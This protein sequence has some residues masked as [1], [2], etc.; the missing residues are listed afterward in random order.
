[1][2]MGMAHNILAAKVPLRGYDIDAAA[3]A[4]FAAMGGTLCADAA[5]AAAQA[6]V[7]LVM[8][9]D[10]A[11]AQQVLFGTGGV[12][13][14][15]PQGATVMLCATM[16][17]A[18]VRMLAAQAAQAGLA[19]LDAPVSGGKAG[20]DQGT[21]SVMASGPAHSFAAAKPLLDAIAA[22]V[23]RLGD[24]PGLGATYKVVHQLAAGVH[25]A[26]AAELMLL[27]TRA[28]CDPAAL[29][30]I[31]SASAGQSWMLADRVPHMLAGDYTPRSMVDIFVKDMGLVLQT[32]RECATPLPL[33][34]LAYQ[35]FVSASALGYGKADDAAVLKAYEALCGA[36]TTQASPDASPSP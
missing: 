18:D 5:T 24:E 34:A 36:T 13:A 15:M 10:V 25:L 2:G 28:G 12:A 19:V 11:Q 30:E 14:A 31:V 1:M 29:F 16:A 17:P 32:G 9:V 20:A 27:G 7:V 22:R 33:A 21:L 8:V 4:R 6:D 26:A 23:Y 3:G 35:M